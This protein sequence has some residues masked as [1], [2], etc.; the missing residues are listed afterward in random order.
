LLSNRNY[1]LGYLTTEP[2]TRQRAFHQPAQPSAAVLAYEESTKDAFATTEAADALGV[3][4]MSPYTILID[5]PVL[6]ALGGQDELYC[7]PPPLVDTD[8]TSAQTV[9]RQ[10]APYYSPAAR[11]R[12]YLLPGHYGHAFNY[13]PNTYLFYQFVAQ[14]AD[15]LVGR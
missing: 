7:A 4:A 11:L 9:Y 8:C 12:T 5:V 3:A 6:I 14:W 2:G 1:D 15:E 10:E 13:A